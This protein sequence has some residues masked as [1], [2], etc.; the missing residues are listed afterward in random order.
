M[1]YLSSGVD[2]RDPPGRSCSQGGPMTTTV[3]R[4]LSGKGDVYAVGPGD[5]IYDA[6]R[7]MADR[8]IGAVLVLSDQKIEGIFSE[9]DY[10]RK[11]VL[12][13]KAS[14][15]TPVR[16]IMTADVISVDPDWTAEQCMALMTEKRVR[17]LPVVEN[18]RVV[19]V[20]S[21]G[22]VVRTIVDEHR[23]TIKSLEGY[24]LSGG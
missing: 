7:L 23:F 10:A 2:G 18:E 16:E 5:T 12:L 13:G 15:E 22:D 8:N 3:R 11:V 14:K 24:I 1:G 19:G 21:I 20:I 17:H 6:L 4:M 9:R